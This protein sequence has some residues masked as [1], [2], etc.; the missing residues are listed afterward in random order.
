MYHQNVD[1]ELA[2][3]VWSV[4]DIRDSRTA[5]ARAVAAARFGHNKSAQ[6]ALS[7]LAVERRRRDLEQEVGGWGDTTKR[8]KIDDAEFANDA[9]GAR[10]IR[11]AVKAW[12]S[13]KLADPKDAVRML[14]VDH[15]TLDDDGN[16]DDAAVRTAID[17]L[18]RR[19]PYLAK[20]YDNGG[21]ADD[22]AG[23]GDGG[24][25]PRGSGPPRRR[26]G[27]AGRRE[28]QRRFGGGNDAA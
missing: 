16:V 10:T 11:S 13:L 17:D 6:N 3:H 8:P 12:A 15:F 18:L 14:D 19:K 28:A 25:G 2:T 4:D 21:G 9:T 20:G 7:D 5:H 24:G 27:D 22:D 23:S 1:A 26:F